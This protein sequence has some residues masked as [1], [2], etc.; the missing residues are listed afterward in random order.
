MQR[1][2]TVPNV[3]NNENHE[4]FQHFCSQRKKSSPTSHSIVNGKISG[5]IK[6]FS[7]LI[8]FV[9]LS[10]TVDLAQLF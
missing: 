8:K 7:S 2:R 3:L 10:F 1:Q 4:K 9:K 5:G 6:G